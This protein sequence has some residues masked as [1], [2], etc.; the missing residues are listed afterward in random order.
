MPFFSASEMKSFSSSSLGA[1]NVTFIRERLP[2]S[3]VPRKNEDAS[4]AS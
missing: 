1:R 2:G 3:A 4:I